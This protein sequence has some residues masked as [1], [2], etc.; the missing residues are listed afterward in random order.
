VC[1]DGA[2]WSVLSV[3]DAGDGVGSDVIERMFN[4]FFTT[5]APGTGLGLAIV[6]EVAVAHGGTVAV[7]DGSLGGAR[8]VVT[9]P[10]PSTPV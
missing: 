2:A 6:R 1:E 7:E 8:F 5:R 9:L 4:P 3:R 10:A